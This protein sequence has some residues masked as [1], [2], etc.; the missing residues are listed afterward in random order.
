M[1]G[2]IGPGGQPVGYDSNIITVVTG[3]I[4]LTGFAHT[5][6]AQLTEAHINSESCTPGLQSLVRIYNN[7]SQPITTVALQSS[8]NGAAL[9]PAGTFNVSIA[10]ATSALVALNPTAYA[11]NTPYSLAF[12]ITAVNGS[13]DEDGTNDTL[14][15]SGTFRVAAEAKGRWVAVRFTQD[16]F[17]SQSAWYITEQ[18]TGVVKLTG[19]PYPDLPGNGTACTP[20]A[21]KQIRINVTNLWLP[22]LPA[23]ALIPEPVQAVSPWFPMELW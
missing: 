20:T 22:M 14:S 19:G 7:G 16:K 4:T 23:M 8:L 6:D 17:G 5:R 1:G 15:T 9:V 21:L 3:P 13:P 2:G 11:T 18:G 10:P 12:K